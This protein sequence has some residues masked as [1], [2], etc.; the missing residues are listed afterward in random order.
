MT[1]PTLVHCLFKPMGSQSDRIRLE[2]NT[3]RTLRRNLARPGGDQA[4]PRTVELDCSAAREKSSRFCGKIGAHSA[5]VNAFTRTRV[6]FHCSLP[7]GADAAVSKFG[8]CQ[9][10]QSSCR[11]QSASHTHQNV[12]LITPSHGKLSIRRPGKGTKTGRK[13][14]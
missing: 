10:S 13:D 1:I 2:V 4:S 7:C 5:F 12:D 11:L 8:V 3:A 9:A 14:R 6:V